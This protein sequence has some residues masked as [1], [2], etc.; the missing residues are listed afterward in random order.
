MKQRGRFQCMKQEKGMWM[1]W[2]NLFIRLIPTKN[3][4]SLCTIFPPEY[5]IPDILRHFLK[6]RRRLI[7]NVWSC[8]T[9][10]HTKNKIHKL[11]C[12]AG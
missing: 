11:T 3:T 1:I 5:G 10:K 4:V 8:I 2:K 12:R 9:T 6:N 7:G